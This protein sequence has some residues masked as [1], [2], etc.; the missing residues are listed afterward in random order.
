[1]TKSEFKPVLKIGSF[2]IHR[3]DLGIVS[4]FFILGAVVGYYLGKKNR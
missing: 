4:V 1:M 3:G 2:T